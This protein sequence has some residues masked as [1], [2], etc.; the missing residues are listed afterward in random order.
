MPFTSTIMQG[1][2][3]GLLKNDYPTFRN[4]RPVAHKRITAFHSIMPCWMYSRWRCYTE[5]AHTD[6]NGIT[7][8]IADEII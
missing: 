4:I 8:N 1:I 6:L 3:F 5:G 2:Q 7:W